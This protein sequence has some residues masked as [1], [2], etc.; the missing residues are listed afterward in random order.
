MRRDGIRRLLHGLDGIDLG[1][2]TRLPQVLPRRTTQLAAAEKG[3]P[4]EIH[5]RFYTGRMLATSYKD[6]QKFARKKTHPDRR[7]WPTADRPG[8]AQRRTTARPFSGSRTARQCCAGARGCCRGSGSRRCSRYF[9]SPSCLPTW[10]RR[11]GPGCR[12][13]RSRTGPRA[14]PRRSYFGLLKGW[15][16]FSVNVGEGGKLGFVCDLRLAC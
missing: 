2:R 16:A 15:P 6:I 11:P 3:R 12:R 13:A 10:S 7:Q 9:P 1:P 8:R 4:Y 5:E 14:R